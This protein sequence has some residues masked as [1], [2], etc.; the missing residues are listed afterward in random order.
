MAS[1]RGSTQRV[2]RTSRGRANRPPSSR[3]TRIPSELR[4]FER[5]RQDSNLGTRFR[6]PML[7]PLSYGGGAGAIGGRK[8]GAGPLR[9]GPSGRH[10]PRLPCRAVLAVSKRSLRALRQRSPARGPPPAMSHTNRNPS[11]LPSDRDR[12][13]DVARTAPRR[14]RFGS[15]R[16]KEHAERLRSQVPSPSL[17]APGRLG[18]SPRCVRLAGAALA[19][20]FEQGLEANR[21][22]DGQP[23]KTCV[24]F[25]LAS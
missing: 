16:H 2:P 1:R 23:A 12:L 15:L 10:G 3:S 17:V 21:S 18:A 14:L 7:Y 22:G 6:K 5:P 9:I 13:R 4:I 19:V 11:R 20:A 8:P 24:W 25:A